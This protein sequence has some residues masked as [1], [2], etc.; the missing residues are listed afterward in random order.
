M[1]YWLSHRLCYHNLAILY[2]VLFE[3][4]RHAYPIFFPTLAL[5]FGR[6]FLIQGFLYFPVSFV[7]FN[8]GPFAFTF[9]PRFL[10]F[11]FLLL[12]DLRFPLVIR[13]VKPP[14]HWVFYTILSIDHHWKL[15][16]PFWFR[17]V[18][19]SF[20]LLLPFI[21][22]VTLPARSLVWK[23]IKPHILPGLFFIT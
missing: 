9:G 15:F 11:C 13:S 1:F 10:F 18:S 3:M 12:D 2:G 22:V 23:V 17:H 5:C 20:P 4:G 19:F 16:F 14:W 7:S 8:L 21:F 6:P